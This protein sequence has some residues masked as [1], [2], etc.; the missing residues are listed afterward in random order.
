MD[1][2]SK[3][4]WLPAK[5]LD[6]EMYDEAQK[7]GQTFGE[8][9]E[10]LKAE[11]EG[12]SPYAGMTQFEVIKAKRA[13]R[14]AGKLPTPTAF[15]EIFTHF[16]VNIGGAASD[17]VGKFFAYP[18]SSVLMGEYISQV[19]ASSLIGTSMVDQLAAIVERTDQPDFRSYT[20]EDDGTDLELGELSDRQ[21]L[22]DL[23][24]NVDKVSRRTLKYGRYLKSGFDDLGRVTFNALN[25]ALRKIGQQI[26]VAETSELI[27][28][29]IKGDGTVSAPTPYNPA[30]TDTINASE[31]IG[32]AT[33]LET[34]YMVDYLIA[35]KAQLQQYLAAV[36]GVTNPQTA[37]QAVSVPLPKTVDW[38]KATAA[39]G[40]EDDYIL[41]M[42]SRHAIG[43]VSSMGVMVESERLVKKQIQGTGIWYRSAFYKLDAN[44]VAVMD[45]NF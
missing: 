28:I 15:D 3:F 34:P 23:W 6:F 18:D 35:K 1:L 19:V 12:K 22:P 43:G 13:A 16:K 25:L 41:V 36:V 27:R 21:E 14:A 29:A 26:G 33:K 30:N 5:S 11:K 40:L 31:I 42:D 10:G 8:W 38:N 37:F 32:L 45:V 20:F 2:R 17:L 39:S 24:I 7:K 44:A 4:S 9:L